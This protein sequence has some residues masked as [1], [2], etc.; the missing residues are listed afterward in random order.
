MLSLYRIG[1]LRNVIQVTKGYE[2]GLKNVGV[3]KWRHES[4][5][6]EEWMTILEE[7][8]VYQKL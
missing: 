2:E 1:A 3:R 6:G 4:Q 7:A 5:D 8:K